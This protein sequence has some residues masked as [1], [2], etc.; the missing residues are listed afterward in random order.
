M[1]AAADSANN[2][3]IQLLA[4]LSGRLHIYYFDT[5]RQRHRIQTRKARARQ[6]DKERE[7]QMMPLSLCA[8]LEPEGTELLLV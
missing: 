2:A 7:L 4:A 3:R 8:S 5:F 1:A 6:D